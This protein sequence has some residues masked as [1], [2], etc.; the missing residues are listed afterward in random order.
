MMLAGSFSFLDSMYIPAIVYIVLLKHLFSRY[1]AFRRLDEILFSEAEIHLKQQNN[2]S[3]TSSI[4][5]QT[6]T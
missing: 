3:L 2:E 6:V 5:R 1:S 4:F